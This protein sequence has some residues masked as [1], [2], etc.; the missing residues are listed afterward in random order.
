MQGDESRVHFVLD[1]R[2]TRWPD[3]DLLDE[4]AIT[5]MPR[6]FV[7]GRNSWIA[8]GFVR[9]RRGLQ[10]R[11]LRVTAG[12]GFPAGA[13][14]LVHR[15]DLD[16]FSSA[17][18]RRFLV[19]VRADRAP[20]QACDFAIA[21][22][23]LALRSHERFVPLW[24]QPGLLPR[25]PARDSR[26]ETL[27]YFGR[28]SSAPAWF[29]DGAW[30]QALT[31]RGVRFEVRERAWHDYRSVDVALAVRDESRRVLGTKPATKLYNG[32][33]AQVPVI[34]SPEPAYAA[35]RENPLDFLEVRDAADVLAA[36]DRLRA[37]PA[38]YRAMAWQGARRGMS[39]SVAAVARCWLDLFDAEL[40]PAYMAWRG[41][42]SARRAWFWGAMLRQKAAG[43][44]HRAVVGAER[45]M[46]GW[47]ARR[48]V[49]LHVTGQ[50]GMSP[51][52]D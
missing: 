4:D 17:A 52:G 20:V 27:A 2:R 14:C 8:Q 1:P 24:P 15:D 21:Q 37:Q 19:G 42:G 39:F 47:A 9:L 46:A 48:E 33:L 10:A 32:W 44:V 38:L 5:R 34:A 29:S 41:G 49:T 43:R 12:A 7:G 3:I 45:T 13:L 51:A 18:Y 35:L 26:V 36:I 6:R 23:P 22:N 31:R 16:R 28:T 40:L 11:G 30:R 25:D 50:S